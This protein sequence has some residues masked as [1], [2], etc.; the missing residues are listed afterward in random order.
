MLSEKKEMSVN[1]ALSRKTLNL[2][3]GGLPSICR[4]IP[5]HEFPPES[6]IEKDLTILRQ[7]DSHVK[8]FTGSGMLS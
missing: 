6:D 1:F 8:Y 7:M 5:R 4:P 2:Y 3:M